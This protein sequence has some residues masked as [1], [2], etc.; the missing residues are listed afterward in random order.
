MSNSLPSP[1]PSPPEHVLRK[2]IIT[3]HFQ[4]KFL[5]DFLYPKKIVF[6][7]LKITNDIFI[8]IN[9]KMLLHIFVYHCTF[10][11]HCTLK[12]ALVPKHED[13]YYY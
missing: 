4:Q 3:A 12:Q 10:V 1:A 6:I 11:P 9:P 13:Y 8:V 2:K 5:N 7:H